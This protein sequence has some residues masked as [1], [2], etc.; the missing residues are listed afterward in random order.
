[1]IRKIWFSIQAIGTCLFHIIVAGAVVGQT[2]PECPDE[3]TYMHF[4]VLVSAFLY[5]IFGL[6]V[7]L[8]IAADMIFDMDMYE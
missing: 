6:T 2:L 8:R 5:M 1:M 4:I 3:D 7:I